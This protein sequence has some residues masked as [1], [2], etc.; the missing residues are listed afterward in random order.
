MAETLNG[1]WPL[2]KVEMW[3]VHGGMKPVHISQALMLGD[4][5][6][7]CRIKER[8]CGS[9]DNL[10]TGGSGGRSDLINVF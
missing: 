2:V 10:L 8:V 5:L 9:S 4:R 3:L 7:K 1:E 6:S